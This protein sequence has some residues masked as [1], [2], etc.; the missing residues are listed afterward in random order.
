MPAIFR[1]PTYR[2]RRVQIELRT[3]TSPNRPTD[4]VE[5]LPPFDLTEVSGVQVTTTGSVVVM[6][7]AVAPVIQSWYFRPMNIEI[8]GKSYI[9]AF[10]NFGGVSNPNVANDNDIEKLLKLRAI[11]NTVFVTPGL[12][13]NNFGIILRY[14]DPDDRNNINVSQEY[15]GYIEDI[16]F[17][18]SDTEP[19]MKSYTIKY[20]GSLKQSFDIQMGKKAAMQ[21]KKTTEK[22]KTSDIQDKVKAPNK[23]KT[24][25]VAGTES[26]TGLFVMSLAAVGAIIAVPKLVRR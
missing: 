1:N 19:Y 16:S 11:V 10:S 3:Q 5:D 14:D 24:I 7:G 23:E 17:N 26:R 4:N 18:E 21:D 6:T 13:T 15:L 20:V 25:K 8:S 2:K 22:Q 9:G 12:P